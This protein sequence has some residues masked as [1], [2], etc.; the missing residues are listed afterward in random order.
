VSK[1]RNR[2]FGDILGRKHGVHV[3]RKRWNALN[4]GHIVS[5]GA[6]GVLHGN[7][8]DIKGEGTGE[9][10][11]GACGPTRVRKD[12]Q[13]A[14][15]IQRRRRPFGGPRGSCGCISGISH[16]AIILDARPFGRPNRKMMRTFSFA[17]QKPVRIRF[18]AA[19]RI[20]IEDLG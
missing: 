17:S 4:I 12:V 13:R 16:E 10:S 11:V 14:H 1:E 7:P 19:V 6:P 15:S 2:R 20:V 5:I 8:L 9:R 18:V 3:C